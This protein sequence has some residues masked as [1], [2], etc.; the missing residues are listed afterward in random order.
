MTKSSDISVTQKDKVVDYG[1]G[2]SLPV[3]SNPLIE[4]KELPCTLEELS[5]LS[6]ATVRKPATRDVGNH[7]NVRFVMD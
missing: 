4:S 7:V 5:L 2:I 1:D 3:P 6:E